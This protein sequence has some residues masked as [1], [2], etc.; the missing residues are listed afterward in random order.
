MRAC[1]RTARS[2]APPSPPAASRW[3]S[4]DAARQ[5]PA[6]HLRQS[7]VR[8]LLR[9]PRRGSARPPGHHAAVSGGRRRGDACSSDAPA[10]AAACAR[11]ARTA[12]R[13]EVELS[14]GM[15]HGVD[16]RADPLGAR[17][18]RP[19]R[20]RAHAAKK[21]Q[22]SLR[23]DRR[24][25]P[26]SSNALSRP[27]TAATARDRPASWRC[28]SQMTTPS[29]TSF[30]LSTGG[31]RKP[32][33]S[34]TATTAAKILIGMAESPLL[35]PQSACT[36]ATSQRAV[37]SRRASSSRCADQ[38][39]AQRQAVLAPHQRQVERG[40]AAQ[41][42]ERAERRIAGRAEA[43]RAR[44]PARTASAPRRSARTARRI[45]R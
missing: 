25:A 40:H 22:A 45:P 12:R 17:L 26:C 32:S 18:R 5:G 2:A 4:S 21:L 23:A 3:R 13:A 10:R 39:H 33:T 29:A 37:R 43:L 24:A 8:G 16:G 15:V 7:R 9:L 30:S 42:P 14:I 41:R 20:N 44:C 36:C 35:A 6:A 31:T 11:A 27:S 28:R 1:S 19:Q 38:L 34:T